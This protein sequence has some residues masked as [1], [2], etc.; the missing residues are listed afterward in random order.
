MAKENKLE[1]IT[2]DEFCS[3][4]AGVLDVTDGKLNDKQAAMIKEKLTTV[5]K[6]LNFFNRPETPERSQIK[7]FWS[8]HRHW[9]QT[10]GTAMPNTEETII[11]SV[12]DEEPPGDKS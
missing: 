7:D 5:K 11:C 12:Q 2:S 9:P 1:T 8:P 4:L 6:T 3:W 10:Y